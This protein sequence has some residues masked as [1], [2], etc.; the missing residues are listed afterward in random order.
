MSICAMSVTQKSSSEVFV[1]WRINNCNG[2]NERIL[3]L[4]AD[5]LLLTLEFDFP[6]IPIRSY[7]C[8]VVWSMSPRSKLK[9]PKTLTLNCVCDRWWN[10]NILTD[11]L[12]YE[13]FGQWPWI[14][15]FCPMIPWVVCSVGRRA[16]GRAQRTQGG[17]R[18]IRLADHHLE[19]F[20]AIVQMCNVQ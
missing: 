17:G 12:E 8:R 9:M 4:K 11:N 7:Y 18:H 6:R 1:T 16:A 5:F 10:I 14:S 13:Y 20:C 15:I 3:T 19:V 2:A